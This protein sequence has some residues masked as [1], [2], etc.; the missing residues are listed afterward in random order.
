MKK[1]LLL[2]VL[3][4]FALKGNAQNNLVQ[5][6]VDYFFDECL[7]ENLEEGIS[8][9]LKYKGISET[10]AA[11][12]FYAPFCFKGDQ[13]REFKMTN[14]GL[15]QQLHNTETDLS[16]LNAFNKNQPKKKR[17][18]LLFRVHQQ[19]NFDTFSILILSLEKRN[20]W[21]EFTM[22]LFDL[23]GNFM[24]ATTASYNPSD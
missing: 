24:C 20:D 22:I 23:E 10:K 12:R 5:K 16:K 1:G 11:Y 8:Y 19:S 17:Q 14:Y 6:G 7:S 3:S 18:K 21:F 13:L 2:I 9:K 15:G 4:L